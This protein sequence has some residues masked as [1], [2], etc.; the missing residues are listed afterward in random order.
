MFSGFP[1]ILGTLP[2]VDREM[3]SE[4][5]LL[6]CPRELADEIKNIKDGMAYETVKIF[7]T[8][9]SIADKRDCLEALNGEKGSTSGSTGAEARPHEFRGNLKLRVSEPPAPE[10]IIW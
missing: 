9:D 4:R 3:L 10:Q 2:S 5:L 7:I 1:H 6:E 8:F